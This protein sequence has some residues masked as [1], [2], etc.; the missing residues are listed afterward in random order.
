MTIPFERT[1]AVNATREFLTELAYTTPRLPKLVRA[2]AL[3]LLRHY[4][5]KSDIDMVNTYFKSDFIECPFSKSDATF[6]NS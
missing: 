1:R 3:A 5:S 2:K 4:P 6:L